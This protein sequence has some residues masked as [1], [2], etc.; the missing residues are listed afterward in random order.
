MSTL[1][2]ALEQRRGWTSV[3]TPR[4]RLVPV[5]LTMKLELYAVVGIHIVLA[6]TFGVI[7]VP[8]FPQHD[9]FMSCS[10]LY[11]SLHGIIL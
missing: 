4:S 9:D 7:W 3:D 1:L 8:L 2:I 5:P 10:H 6:A 11:M